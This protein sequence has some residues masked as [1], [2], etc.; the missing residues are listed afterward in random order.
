MSFA[1]LGL[2][3]ASS[4]NHITNNFWVSCQSWWS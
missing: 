2:F 3:L 4:A 1:D